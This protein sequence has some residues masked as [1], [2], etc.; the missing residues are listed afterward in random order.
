MGAKVVPFVLGTI[1]NKNTKVYL[2]LKFIH[3]FSFYKRK[4]DFKGITFEKV[5]CYLKLLLDSIF[6]KNYGGKRINPQVT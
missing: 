3:S 4:T 2:R 5:T 1:P 6:Q